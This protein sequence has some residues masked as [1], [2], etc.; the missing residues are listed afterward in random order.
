MKARSILLSLATGALISTAAITASAEVQGTPVQKP[1]SAFPF[2]AGIMGGAGYATLQHPFISKEIAGVGGTPVSFT[3]ATLGLHVGYTFVEHL[4]VGLE[5]QALET[6]ISRNNAGE[7]FKLGYSTQRGCNNC[8]PPLS[9]TDILATTV[10]F[11]TFAARLEYTP[12]GRDGFFL[13][14]SAGLASI[15]GYDDMTGVGFSGRLGYRFRPT[16]IMTISLEGG[17]QGQ[18]YG[19]ANIYMPYGAAVLRPYF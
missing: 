1:V 8:H 19:D 18:V 9:G 4:S 12:F 3:A 7:T 14:G 5:F 13:G 2:Y 11:S 17:V 15:V 6:G 16:N 10:V